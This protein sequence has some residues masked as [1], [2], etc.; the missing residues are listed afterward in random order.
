M[1]EKIKSNLNI[2][3]LPE[4]ETCEK[5]LFNNLINFSYL[6]DLLDLD[7]EELVIHNNKLVIYDDGSN[8]HETKLDIPQD[9]I[10]LSFEILCLKKNIKFNPFTPFVSFNKFIDSCELR[11]SCLHHSSGMDNNKYFL[12]KKR[13]KIFE[14]SDFIAKKDSSK[15][16]NIFKSLNNILISGKSG[17]GKTTFLQSMLRNFSRDENV[18]VLEDTQ[19]IHPTFPHWLLLRINEHIHYSDYLKYSVRM[20]L[21]RIILGEIRSHEVYPFILAMNTGVK[22]FYSTLHANSALDT[23]N[24]IAVLFEI[25]SKNSSL[26]F[27]SVMKLVCSQIDYV[28]YLEEKKIKEIIKVI[29]FD[30]RI[31]YQNVT[32]S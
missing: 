31:I 1:I 15:I 22:G 2:G 20:K 28:F 3:V 16:I 18:I 4:I 30:E 8:I 23:L 21:N 6:K 12:R 25:Y 13:N 17:S 7:F 29:G 26:K 14:A 27:E 24:R 5:N 11:I 10:D 9:I 32:F 19:E